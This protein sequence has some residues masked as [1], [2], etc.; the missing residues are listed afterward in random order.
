MRRP[1]GLCALALFV[2]FLHL[3]FTREA[4]ASSSFLLWYAL[5]NLVLTFWASAAEQERERH[6]EQRRDGA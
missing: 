6:G 2:V 3:E 5:A 1:S 4:G